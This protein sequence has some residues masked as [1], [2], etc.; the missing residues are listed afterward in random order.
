MRSATDP[1]AAIEMRVRFAAG[2]LALAVAVAL[3][4]CHSVGPQT[5]EDD[6]VDYS[7]AITESWK[8]QTL[9][10]V[11]KL[12]YADPPVFVDVGQI[13][14]GYTLETAVSVGAADQD[15]PLGTTSSLSLGG[16]GR[17]TDRPT[18][19][20]VP[21]TGSSF[22]NS[23]ITPLAPV[24]LFSAIQAG[25]PADSIVRLGVSVINGIANEQ[26]SGGG[27][28]PAD[29]EF[30]RLI[31][32]LRELQ[33][34]GALTIRVERGPEGGAGT[35]FVLRND[36][37][38]P[39]TAALG[40][41]L[42]GLLRLDPERADFAL[43]YGRTAATG[44]EIAV[45]SRSLLNI[46]QLMS[47]QAVVPDAHIA[48]GRA[49]AMS[50]NVNQVSLPEFRILSSQDRPP[51]PYVAQRYRDTWFYVDDTDLQSK[52]IFALIMMLF[53]LADTSP[54]RAAPVITIPAQ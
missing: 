12:R 1:F 21:L 5:V 32:L 10:N 13:V 3:G 41:E 39:A 26:F 36:N 28:A 54:Q 53:T 47:G 17:F 42:R 46:L 7:T 33:L 9:L 4:G 49:S 20:Y 15:S 24:S 35:L 14:A 29:P 31:E 48:Q 37:I 16:S 27:Y 22:I 44:G 40:R 45:Q 6:R 51:T 50:D 52:R 8:Q 34:S 2:S 23:L 18:I 38:T 11:V 43:V 19:T 25:W 30:P